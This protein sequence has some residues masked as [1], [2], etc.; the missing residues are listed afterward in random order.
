MADPNVRHMKWWGWGHEDVSFSD[1]DKPKLWSYLERELGSQ[2]SS[3]IPPVKFEEVTLPIAKENRPLLEALKN[4]LVDDQISA[5]KKDR[6]IHAAGKAFRDLLRLR[7][8]Q[9]DYAPDLVVY[10]VSEEEVVAIVNAANEHDAVIIPFG[11]GTN[12]A[13]CLEP[14]DKAGRFVISLDMCRMYRVLEVDKFSLTARIEAGVYGPHMEEQLEKHGVTLGHF[15]DSF[16]HSTLGGWAATRSAGMQSDK[17]GKIEDMVI[18]IRMV[19]PSGTIISRTVPKSSN[20]IDIRQLCIGSEGILGVITEVTMQVHRVPEYKEFYGWI[21]PGFESGAAAIHECMRLGCMPVI[22]RLND[23]KKTALSFAFKKTQSPFKDF[24]GKCVKWYLGNIKRIDFET[25]CIMIVACEGSYD[26][27]H[28]Q[29][30]ESAH[31]FRK[32]GGVC[33][34]TGPG[35]SFQEAKFDF[36]HV[37]DYLMDRGV[38]GDVSETSTT[39]NNLIPMYKAT[40]AAIEK[41]IRNTGMDPWVGCHISHNYHTGA[42]LYFTFGCRQIVGR[43][44]EQYLYIKKA[45]E[46]A[47]MTIGGTVSHHHA[48]GCEHLPWIEEDISPAGMK[49]V[50]ALKDG[51]DPKGVMNPGKIIPGEDPLEEWGLTEEAIQ[52]FNKAD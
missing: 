26:T 52:S 41:A 32:H 5:N 16:I 48:V 20:G 33:L 36:P 3:P 12:I 27:F 13:G 7:R 43:E 40:L 4:A 29:R 9:V 28:M 44:M 38:M 21:F 31:I 49:A 42:S 15:P 39:W 37:R 50:K 51:L 25:C 8:G 11:G 34:G 10:P 1:A 18:S 24:V 14:H 23:P 6:L 30:R 35:R 46:D 2:E 22:A 45:A 47:F 17:Y 19:T